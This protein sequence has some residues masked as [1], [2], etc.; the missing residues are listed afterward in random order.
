LVPDQDVRIV[1]TGL[2]PGEKLFEE[3]FDEAEQVE[4]TTH[5]K[6]RRAVKDLS[7]REQPIG[8][9]IDN[10]EAAVAH[11]DDEGVIRTLQDA[12][13]TYSPQTLSKSQPLVQ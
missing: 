8:L 10:L 13:P 7:G 4:P 9:M 12:V 6:I 3:L 5:P 1:Y 11:G 2:R